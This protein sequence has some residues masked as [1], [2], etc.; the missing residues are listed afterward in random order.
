VLCEQIK[1]LIY[2]N[3]DD[4][5]KLRNTRKIKPDGS[6]V[7]E[8]DLLCE[9]LIVNFIRKYRKETFEIL[10]EETDSSKFIYDS[11]KNYIV[12]DPIDGTENFTSGLKEWGVAICIYRQGSHSESAL[13]LP[14][15]DEFL[16]T[17][18]RFKR[19]ESRIMGIS[20][21]LTKQE[22]LALEEGFEYRII[23]CCVYNMFNVITGAYSAFE[24]PKG[25]KIWDI[26]P[27]LNLALENNLDVTVNGVKYEGKFLSPHEKY[28]FKIQK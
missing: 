13:I 25:A 6:Y 10:S 27:G 22:I 5:L 4:I 23:G 18:D 9:S 28:R 21:S 3:L 24:N 12:I 8:G 15:L 17:G 19:H 7:T 16:K 20:S 26:L 2:Q 14:E 11:S 1:S